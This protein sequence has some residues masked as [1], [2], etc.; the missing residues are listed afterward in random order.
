MAK[1]KSSIRGKQEKKIVVVK[2]Y[3]RKD[4]VKVG[5]HRRSTPNLK[6]WLH[7]LPQS[8]SEAEGVL[9]FNKK[10]SLVMVRKHMQCQ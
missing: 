8:F 3:T 10:V 1:T 5:P 6:V 2:E 4:G 9:L 7:R